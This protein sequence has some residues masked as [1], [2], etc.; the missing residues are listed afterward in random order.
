MRTHVAS[1]GLKLSYAVDD[2]SD[3]WRPQETLFLLHAAMGSSRRLYKWVPILSRDFRVVRPDMRGHGQSAVP[4]PDQLSVARLA[5][6]VAEIADALGC[7]QFHV[8]GSSAG[9]IVAMQVA[10]DYPNRVKTLGDFA[11][12][13]GLKNSLVDAEQWIARIK[14]AVSAVF[15]KTPSATGC[16]K[17]RTQASSG[18]SSM[19]RQKPTPSCFTALCG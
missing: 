6:D 18:G 19:N 3:P 15:S 13:P 7:K 2:Y 10:I 4:G 1:D 11:S 12:T 16:R 8:A 17:T 5:A 14:G 9:A